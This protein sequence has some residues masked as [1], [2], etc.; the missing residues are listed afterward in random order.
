MIARLISGALAL[1]LLSYAKDDRQD[2]GSHPKTS[3]Y[4]CKADIR[5]A[6]EGFPIDLYLAFMMLPLRWTEKVEPTSI[7]VLLRR[8]ST[9]VL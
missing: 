2:Q 6:C 3:C 5:A 8:W 7:R 4:E 9:A 1:L